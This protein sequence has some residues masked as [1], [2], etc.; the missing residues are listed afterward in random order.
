MYQMAVAAINKFVAEE[1]LL[2]LRI[3]D[4]VNIGAFTRAMEFDLPVYVFRLLDL[5][6]AD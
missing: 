5:Q 2:G 4:G 3:F 6:I 1:F